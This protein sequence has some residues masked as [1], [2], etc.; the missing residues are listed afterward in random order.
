MV[1][2]QIKYAVVKGIL[3]EHI[4]ENFIIHQNPISEPPFSPN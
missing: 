1:I 2:S 3:E 4:E